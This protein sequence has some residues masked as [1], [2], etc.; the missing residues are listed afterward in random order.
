[1]TSSTGEIWAM[2]HAERAALAEDLQFLS[3]TQWA[4]QSL[5]SAWSVR[6]VVAHLSAAASVGRFRWIR[7][8]LG[9]RFNF[10]LHNQRRMVEHLGSSNA[11]TLAEFRR[12]I[13]SRTAPLGH[14]TAWL[15]EVIVHSADIRR[16]LGIPSDPRPKAVVA[17]ARFYASRD[18]TVPSQR[19]IDG[20]RLEATDESFSVGEGLLVRG[21]PLA[22]TMAMAGRGAF[23]DDLTGDGVATLRRRC[24]GG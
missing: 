5:C 15:G 6:E 14:P 4:S 13:P 23:C 16:P 9:A 18:F 11:D 7:S 22:L 17:V 24:S 8:V 20:L 3:D 21:T 12:T 19:A 1:M 10:D 2:I